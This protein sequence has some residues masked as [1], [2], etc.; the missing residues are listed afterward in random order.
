MEAKQGC[1]LRFRCC[2]RSETETSLVCYV[3]KIQALV[4]NHQI[5]VTSYVATN[6][7]SQLLGCL[8]SMLDTP[9]VCGCI[10]LRRSF[11]KEV[12]TSRC[13]KTIVGGYCCITLLK[14]LITG[15]ESLRNMRYTLVIGFSVRPRQLQFGK[16]SLPNFNLE[17]S[18]YQ[19]FF[20]YWTVNFQFTNF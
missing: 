2:S 12:V 19:T 14:T 4:Y 17:I 7:Y 10:N 9:L 15:R 3:S 6:R 16:L 18:H 1:M 20:H 13:K 5:L 8:S 11:L